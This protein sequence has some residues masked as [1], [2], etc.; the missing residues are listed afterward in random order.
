[1][2]NKHRALSELEKLSELSG[3]YD[4]KN[5]QSSILKS[6]QHNKMLNTIRMNSMLAKTAAY[7]AGKDNLEKFS[8]SPHLFDQVTQ[9]SAYA[10]LLGFPSA[11]SIAAANALEANKRRVAARNGNVNNYDKAAAL[12]NSAR[13]FSQVGKNVF[14][15][16]T[17]LGM[18]GLADVTK[19][20]FALAPGGAGMGVTKLAGGAD[21]MG[22][23]GA[24]ALGGLLK[25]AGMDGAGIAVQGMNPM[26]AGMMM[27]MALSK[28][29]TALHKIFNKNSEMNLN[30]NTKRD[31]SVHGKQ[32]HELEDM[33]GSTHSYMA[34][35]ARMQQMGQIDAGT[36]ILGQILAS[37]EGHTSVLPLLAADTTNADKKRKAKTNKALNHLSDQFGEDGT[38]SRGDQRKNDDPGIVFKLANR[39]ERFSAEF[40]STFDI[41]GQVSNTLNG[42]SSTRLANEANDIGKKGDLLKAQKDFGRRFGVST[43]MVQ[44]IHTTPT[45]IMNESDSYEGRVIS[46]LGL[47]SEISRFSAHELLQIRSQGFGI[48]AGESSSYLKKM[49]DKAEE[50]REAKD[51]KSEF[52]EN[53]LKGIDETLGYVPGWNMLSGTIKMGKKAIDG[54]K[55]LLNDHKEGN[56]RN[57]KEVF[58]DWLNDGAGNE[59]LKT[60][61]SIRNAI[62]ANELS[63]EQKMST[64]LGGDFPNKFEELLNYARRIDESTAAM[65][66]PIKRKS[67]AQET[68]N[69]FTGKMGDKNYHAGIYQGIND[70]LED[71]L[72]TIDKTKL[73]GAQKIFGAFTSDEARIKRQK[74]TFDKNFGHITDGLNDIMGASQDDKVNENNVSSKSPSLQDQ[75]NA[76]KQEE[77]TVNALAVQEG[78]LNTLVEIR[79]LLRECCGEGKF[80]KKGP[81]EK[82]E[83][84]E[85]GFG[86]DDLLGLGNP[87]GNGRDK[88]NKKKQARKAAE[89]KEKAAKKARRLE[90]LRKARAARKKASGTLAQRTLKRVGIQ[91]ALEALSFVPGVGALAKIAAMGFS[92]YAAYSLANMIFD[93]DGETDADD[94]DSIGD[95][96]RSFG[97]SITN[98]FGFGDQP[99][100][101]T[102][103]TQAAD[104]TPTGSRAQAREASGFRD[105]IDQQKTHF[106]ETYKNLDAGRVTYVAEKGYGNKLSGTAMNEDHPGLDNASYNKLRGLHPTF[107][108]NMLRVAA[109]YN[110]KTGRNLQIT[111]GLRDH[112]K[113]VALY[114]ADKKKNGGVPSGYVAAPGRSRHEYGLAL[115]I[116]YNDKA[117][118]DYLDSTGMLARNG[119]YRPIKNARHPE[120]WHIEPIGTRK[121]GDASNDG[122][123]FGTS[124]A[125]AKTAGVTDVATI[126][127]KTTNTPTSGSTSAQPTSQSNTSSFNGTATTAEANKIS[128]SIK[129][130]GV[131]AGHKTALNDLKKLTDSYIK[132]DGK[133]DDKEKATLAAKAKALEDS[134]E[135]GFSAQF[136]KVFELVAAVAKN[137]D[138]AAQIASAGIS[139]IAANTVNEKTTVNN[140]IAILLQQAQ[141]VKPV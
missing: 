67:R 133:L 30:K 47:I 111:S 121:D 86:L 68:M 35:I 20:S 89:A 85:D 23:F 128:N 13:N 41:M 22:H 115:D 6:L 106:Q 76:Y 136:N 129:S 84:K 58:M 34:A 8:G 139:K 79:D 56:L 14:Y 59:K 62:G 12:T 113:Q 36:A 39:L 37:I 32:P 26:I 98:A 1:M 120:H 3:L 119:I 63:N 131:S 4:A 50:E 57:P 49:Q 88:T 11:G 17:A 109:E 93:D 104:Y 46:I 92:V 72:N 42:K 33:Y 82:E 101:T 70:S 54:S 60:E 65:A 99:T 43:N 87:F 7:T 45:Q 61:E 97:S 94:I 24:N 96:F 21:A 132:N 48:K 15:G 140:T 44:A 102:V 77:R 122:E 73:S 91:T 18:T 95:K 19:N 25:T 124:V 80:G 78:Q 105:I 9:A 114:E 103:D 5:N 38:L 135:K 81:E 31:T 110:G 107:A 66:G 100:G 108:K 28:G 29:G 53:W 10:G 134:G 16:S 126:D 52:Y 127:A 75:Q 27:A 2:S 69:E 64:Y 130:L 74:A 137:T 118:N 125:T 40:Q 112:A 71:E 138:S 123:S 51:N 141:V 55:E 117:T 116:N 90:A 83:E